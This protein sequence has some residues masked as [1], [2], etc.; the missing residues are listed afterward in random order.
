M[1]LDRKNTRDVYPATGTTITAKSWATEAAMR[2]L[3]NNLHPDVAENPHELVVYG[4]IGRAARSWGD[5]DR[6][7]AAL[8]KP[9]G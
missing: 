8:K 6:I 4:G 5:F 7:V 1:D 3:M 9:G 2:M